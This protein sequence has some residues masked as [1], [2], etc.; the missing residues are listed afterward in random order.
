MKCSIKK[1]FFGSTIP[2]GLKNRIFCWFKS[3]HEIKS[4]KNQIK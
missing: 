4:P 1:M 3:T 2:V